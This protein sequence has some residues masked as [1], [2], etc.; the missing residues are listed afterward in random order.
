LFSLAP[1]CLGLFALGVLASLFAL[2]LRFSLPA[3]EPP[4]ETAAVPAMVLDAAEYVALPESPP[5]SEQGIYSILL[6]GIDDRTDLSERSDAM[7]LVTVNRNTQQIF[8]T[9]FLRDLY[10][11]ISGYGSQRLNAANALGGPECTMATIEQNFGVVPDSYAAVNFETFSAV[12]DIL[13]GVEVSLSAEEAAELGLGECAGTFHLDGESALSFCRIRNLDSDFG[14]TRRQRDVLTSLWKNLRNASFG[15][16]AALLYEVLPQLTTDL[17]LDD[18]LALLP[19]ALR[20]S[21]YELLSGQIPAEGTYQLSMVDGMSVIIAD[22][23][24][25]TAILRTTVFCD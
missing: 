18:C 17:T 21:D 11:P 20:I 1:V 14:R 8:L 9:S 23:E 7:I 4:T 13:G 16:A 15:D 24:E 19:V 10:L 2:F 25:N 3:E 12:V 22:L 6:L 5:L